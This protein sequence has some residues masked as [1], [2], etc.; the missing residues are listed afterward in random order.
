MPTVPT[1]CIPPLGTVRPTPLDRHRR[2]SP[3]AGSAFQLIDVGDHSRPRAVALEVA[4]AG[5]VGPWSVD[6]TECVV[7][8]EDLTVVAGASS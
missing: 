3:R 5:A 1:S 7:G 2:A 4:R 6:G 8:L